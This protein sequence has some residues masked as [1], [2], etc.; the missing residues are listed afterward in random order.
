MKTILRLLC[1]LACL[2]LLIWLASSPL[3][4]VQAA[5]TTIEDC[6]KDADCDKAFSWMDRIKATY[7]KAKQKLGLE[8]KE[9]DTLKPSA[10]DWASPEQGT[11]GATPAASPFPPAS[12]QADLMDRDA[13]V[14]AR[15]DSE[16]RDKAL[17]S[18][19]YM[20]RLALRDLNALEAAQA[21]YNANAAYRAAYPDGYQ[22]RAATLA[23]SLGF[24]R[25]SSNKWDDNFDVAILKAQRGALPEAPALSDIPQAAS[26]NPA[27][28]GGATAQSIP[29]N[30]DALGKACR[31]HVN[32][33]NTDER[34][35]K[36]NRD[37]LA[38]TPLAKAEIPDLKKWI[39]DNAAEKRDADS[40]EHLNYEKCI[41]ETRLAELQSGKPLAA[42]AGGNAS[43]SG[44]SAQGVTGPDGKPIDANAP[45]P[46]VLQAL[47]DKCRP[48]G[49]QYGEAA[50]KDINY[51]VDDDLR[52][53]GM[54]YSPQT[55]RQNI[56]N[57][58]SSNTQDNVPINRN[59]AAFRGCVYEARLA[60]L[61][62]AV[63]NYPVDN[64]DNYTR[65]ELSR[66]GPVCDHVVTERG[67]ANAAQVIAAG[68][69]EMLL[70]PTQTA[71]NLQR[72]LK[73]ME[74]LADY[75]ANPE[76]KQAKYAYRACLYEQRMEKLG[77]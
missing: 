11:I 14:S 31:S 37:L 20:C 49:Q 50:D 63:K 17:G 39:A 76:D 33:V 46:S 15:I 51:F 53:W 73:T 41:Y 38:V 69:H 67:V 47:T 23:A 68:Q 29:L 1:V 30:M 26:N 70:R 6:R 45:W 7:H 4:T 56:D 32:S 58:K 65:V 10:A 2:A 74:T 52:N 16:C 55:L 9:S 71:D 64:T 8:P 22:S 34:I 35:E 3:N 44:A 62:D 60:M 12:K 59:S 18:E 36:L 24:S 13:K 57:A 54:D 19:V 5:D 28:T 21:E 61:E 66:M 25:L 75:D 43:A 48:M 40:A 72:E 42:A 27:A 77:F